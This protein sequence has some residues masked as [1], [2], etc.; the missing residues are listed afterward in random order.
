MKLV[1]S[2]PY[3]PVIVN[4]IKTRITDE[5]NEGLPHPYKKSLEK[6]IMGGFHDKSV[7]GKGF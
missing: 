1:P 7:I 3:P 2:V 6:K 4:S 5:L